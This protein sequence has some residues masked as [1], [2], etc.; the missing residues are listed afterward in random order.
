MTTVKHIATFEEGAIAFRYSASGKLQA[1][2]VFGFRLTPKGDRQ[3]R[4]YRDGSSIW[5]NASALLTG[6]EDDFP[7]YEAVDWGS[8]HYLPEQLDADKDCLE[9]DE[10]EY[11]EEQRLSLYSS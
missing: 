9:A 4:L 10:H 1:W 11:W 3:Y 7:G 5:V 8:L 2:K 6:W